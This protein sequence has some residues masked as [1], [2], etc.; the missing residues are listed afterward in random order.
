MMHDLLET[1][2][3]HLDSVSHVSL[4]VSRSHAE[5]DSVILC[6]LMSQLKVNLASRHLHFEILDYVKCNNWAVTEL[7]VL[8]FILK[9]PIDKKIMLKMLGRNLSCLEEK[10]L[11]F[12]GPQIKG[13]ES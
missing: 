6:D 4:G 12:I 8:I 10:P 7:L 5:W 9:V 13:R 1:C 3:I 11:E 2:Q